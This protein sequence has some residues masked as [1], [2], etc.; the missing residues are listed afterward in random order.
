MKKQKQRKPLNTERGIRSSL[1]TAIKTALSQMD[2]NHKQMQDIEEFGC[3]R[4]CLIKIIESKFKEGMSWENY[5]PGFQLDNHGR[6]VYDT[7]G[8]RIYLKQ[9]VIDHI[10]PLADYIKKG[11]SLSTA[12]HYTNLQPLWWKENRSKCAKLD[13]SQEDYNKKK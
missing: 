7:S 10:R 12:N 2:Y 3:T 11:D 4:L 6:P 13:W 1:R 8:N 5:G 9:W